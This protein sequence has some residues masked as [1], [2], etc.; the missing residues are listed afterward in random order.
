MVKQKLPLIIFLLV[1]VIFP[2]LRA[3]SQIR[4]WAPDH[5]Y[6]GVRLRDVAPADVRDLNLPR[7]AGV[8]VEEVWADS[9]AA[10]ADLRA[11]DV[12]WTFATFSVVSVKQFRR[13][14]SEIPPGREVQ[15][16]AIRVGERLKKTVQ[17]RQGELAR[18][19][20]SEVKGPPEHAE[21]MRDFHFEIPPPSGRHFFFFSDRPRLGIKGGNLTEQMGE[22]LGVPEKKGVLVMEVLK[23]SPAEKAGLKAGDVIVSVDERAVSSLQD[24]SRQLDSGGHDLEVVS[25]KR[26]EKR[27]VQIG[28][29]GLPPRAST[30]L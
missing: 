23:D 18:H 3:Q 21:A 6:V 16:E 30:Q 13:L 29:E 24:L 11:G 20:R 7:E 12:I 15:V 28:L 22:F 27:R 5:G 1:G 14:L 26:L 17:I 4:L 19:G 8:Y 25:D 10:G 2:H 9:P